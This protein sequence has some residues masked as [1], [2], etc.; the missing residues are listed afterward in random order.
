[1]V[2]RFPPMLADSLD[3]AL[4]STGTQW[5][6]SRW[7]EA[8]RC[9]VAYALRYEPTRYRL[10]IV[11]DS[12]AAEPTR[13]GEATALSAASGS[14][15]DAPLGSDEI[16]RQVGSLLHACFSWLAEAEMN[17]SVRDWR[18]VLARAGEQDDGERWDPLSISEAR[19]LMPAYLSQWGE[20]WDAWPLEI[21][22]ALRSVRI[23]AVE[24]LLGSH[25]GDA[26]WTTRADLVV[27]DVAGRIWNVDHKSR[28]ATP[29]KSDPHGAI[30]REA[31]V[32][33]QF[34]GT[35]NALREHYNLDYFPGV[36]VNTIVKTKSPAF[37]R[38]PVMLDDH[39]VAMWREG[40]EAWAQRR[41]SGAQPVPNLRECYGG[42]FN[43]PCIFYETCH[44]TGEGGE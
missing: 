42:R 8:A 18:D 10:P 16:A 44:G 33:P 11:A 41:M 23:I 34:L 30:R 14:D 5:G 31:R 43:K 21:G 12:A 13:D 29:S 20:R 2:S 40:Q 4:R 37:F 26:P 6:S 1:M 9:E 3:D 19:R 32:R 27:E 24:L 17:G 25:V 36:I 39:T 22:S 35:A 15:S 7:D 38:T 28:A